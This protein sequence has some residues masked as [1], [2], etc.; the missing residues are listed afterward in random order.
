MP[1]PSPSPYPPHTYA[2]S[3]CPLPSAPVFVCTCVCVCVPLTLPCC[4]CS[5]PILQRE[6]RQ[7]FILDNGLLNVRRM[8]GLLRRR[9]AGERERHSQTRVFARC[10]AG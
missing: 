3:C 1:T 8:Q 9:M 5:G 4:S 6:R 10:V 2:P 7:A